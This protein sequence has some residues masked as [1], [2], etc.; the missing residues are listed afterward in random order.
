MEACPRKQK[1]LSPRPD[2]AQWGYS[3]ELTLVGVPNSHP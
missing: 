3:L 1:L 2:L